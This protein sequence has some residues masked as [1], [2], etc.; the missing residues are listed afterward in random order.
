MS[1][2]EPLLEP[3]HLPGGVADPAGAAG[4][5][6]D[7]PGI[8]AVAL[9]DGRPLWRSPAAQTALLSDGKRLFA[10]RARPPNA[11]EVVVLDVR[12]GGEL[13]LTSDPV[14]LPAWAAEPS[15]GRARIEGPRLRLEWEASA[16]YTGGAPPPPH[17]LRQAI[18]DIV[19]A[20]LVDLKSGAVMPL[21]V[22]TAP[23]AFRRPPLQPEDAGGPWL[24]G[25][26]VVRLVWKIDGDRQT[27][28]LEQ[29]EPVK[30]R[31]LARGR[32]LVAD[33]TP[34]GRHVFV[35]TEPPPA[36]RDAWSIFAAPSG[37]RVATVTHD[38]GARAPAI[39]G[40]RAFY[41]VESPARRALRARDLATDTLAW[42]LPLVAR[43]AGPAPRPRQ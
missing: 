3:R 30:V 5:L 25:A 41:L 2:R 26:T 11:L 33:V 40:D 6:A 18:H 38:A 37:R 19:G 24:A 9:R 43:P 17:I 7:P 32:G 22:E 1:R 14:A 31:R 23:P 4:Y 10:A 12:R 13:V 29:A 36:R 35:R 27:L 16:R 21:A 15:R 34:D 8:V 42:E 20:A 28:S 39:V